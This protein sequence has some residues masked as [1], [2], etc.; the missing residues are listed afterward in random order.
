MPKNW[1]PTSAL[2]KLVHLVGFTYDPEQD[3]IVSRMN[4]PQRKFGYCWA[5]DV[6]A[7]ALGIIIDAEP[8]YFNYGG[9]NWM[10]ELW[11]GQY[12]LESGGEIG[13]YYRNAGPLGMK[14][15]WYKCA[16]NA[17]RLSMRFELI[18][19]GT[20]LLTRGQEIHWWLTGFRWGVFSELDDL[21]MQASITLKD[22]QM[23]EAFQG[24]LQE[25]GYTRHTASGR[26][27]EFTFAKPKTRQPMIRDKVRSKAQRANRALVEKYVQAKTTAGLTDNDPN[28][29]TRE[30]CGPV[31]EEIK[32]W[33]KSM[34]G[35]T[36]QVP[37]SP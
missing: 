24:A 26:T 11:K 31:Y 32:D 35:W 16:S 7:P 20:T 9:R 8:L 1:T 14:P 2:A 33:V 37:F 4:A 3:I 23:R 18:R 17:D 28:G 36:P 25:C 22:K 34:L 21:K 15:K 5:Y 13:V 12:G 27:V 6:S 30:S 29:I 19:R 10:I